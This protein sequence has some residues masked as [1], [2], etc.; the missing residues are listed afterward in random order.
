MYEWRELYS[1]EEKF[2]ISVESRMHGKYPPCCVTHAMICPG[3]KD[4]SSDLCL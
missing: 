1:G 3:R 2:C 4:K